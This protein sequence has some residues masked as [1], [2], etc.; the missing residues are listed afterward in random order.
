M[1]GRD[2]LL[3]QNR[4]SG[5]KTPTQVNEE[6]NQE[7]TADVP[8]AEK[9]LANSHRSL[10]GGNLEVAEYLKSVMFASGGPNNDG[11]MRN[12]VA[13]IEY[14]KRGTSGQSDGGSGGGAGSTGGVSPG[15]VG[16]NSTVELGTE[17]S[18]VF[19]DPPPLRFPDPYI[20]PIPGL[21]PS[22]YQVSDSYYNNSTVSIAPA[23]YDITQFSS[24]AAASNLVDPLFVSPNTSRQQSIEAVTPK[25]G[26][27]DAGSTTTQQTT[28]T[29]SPQPTTTGTGGTASTAFQTPTA[30]TYK[31]A[32]PSGSNTNVLPKG[33]SPYSTPNNGPSLSKVPYSGV[34]GSTAAAG[35][36]R[37][38]PVGAK[39]PGRW[40]FLFNPSEIEIEA[41]PEY[42]VAETWG[43]SDKQNSGQPL[44]WSHNKNAQLKFN[45]VLL[46]GYVFGKQVEELE[47]GIFE[48]F[49]ARDGGGQA[50]PPVLQFV[51]GQKIFGPCVIK[52]ISIKE[53]MWDSGLVVNAE[54]SFTLE[55]VPEWTIDDGFIDVARP[56]KLPNVYDPVPEAKTPTDSRY[57]PAPVLPP[58]GQDPPKTDQKNTPPPQAPAPSPTQPNLKTKC[59]NL[60]LAVRDLYKI[61]STPNILGVPLDT[62]KSTE[63]RL[64]EYKRNYDFANAFKITPLN[65]PVEYTPDVIRKNI[66]KEWKN[67][68]TQA[69]VTTS[70]LPYIYYPTYKANQ[71]ISSGVSY[72]I[73]N[74]EKTQ[75]PKNCK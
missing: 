74:L 54:M 17:L 18:Q 69:G 4:N 47:Q 55:Q 58:P 8:N 64:A 39:Q 20:N 42:K 7:E 52:D 5:T 16:T 41:G 14:W 59:D 37:I 12:S 21:V 68:S 30:T 46:N 67:L 26:S 35:S 60:K 38:S 13:Y 51:W 61:A 70:P 28:S 29:T 24:S 57:P 66:D 2:E 9:S 3:E 48:L 33:S 25:T 49:M 75:I 36:G 19:N 56:G 44:S 22:S 11:S 27:G 71:W 50:G 62:P 6:I 73:G 45:S 63:E 31:S 15:Q 43:V 53:K 23:P 1:P 40:Q 72:L 32:N 10:F 34:T 65:V